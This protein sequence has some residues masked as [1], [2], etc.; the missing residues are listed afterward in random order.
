MQRCSVVAVQQ[1]MQEGSAVPVGHTVGGSTL[2]EPSPLSNPPTSN[3]YVWQVG[4]G[5]SGFMGLKS[6]AYCF[7]FNCRFPVGTR[8]DPKRWGQGKSRSRGAQTP[9]PSSP[10]PGTHRCPC[11]VYTVEH[12][13]SKSHA[14]HQVGGIA[15][16]SHGRKGEAVHLKR[17][18]PRAPSILPLRRAKRSLFSVSVLMLCFT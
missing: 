15:G 11:G 16:C 9:S 17:G 10:L 2:P 1:S 8:A 18:L 14:N 5:H 6:F 13:T 4:Q 12:V 7:F 3:T